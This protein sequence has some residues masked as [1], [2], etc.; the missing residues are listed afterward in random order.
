MELLYVVNQFPKISE[1]FIINELYELDKRGYDITVFAKQRP[2]EEATHEEIQKMGITVYYGEEPALTS[3]PYVCSKDI[4]NKSLLR[5]TLFIDKPSYHIYALHL[6]KQISEV[7]ERVGGVDLIHAHFATPDRLSASYAA[8]YHGIPCTVTAHAH[9]IF[10]PPSVQRLSQV[11][12]RFNHVI[13]PSKYNKRYLRE[14]IEVKTDIS[15]IPA[16]TDVEKF[17]P[18]DGCVSGRLLTVARLVEKK[19]YKY[20]IEAVAELIEQGYN[21]EYHIIGTGERKESVQTRICELGIEDHVKFLGHVSDDELRS[22]LHDAELFILPCVIASNGDRDVAPVAL[23]EAMATETA[24]VSTSVS[25]IPELITSG[26]DG[27]LVEP[28]NSTALADTIAELL[29]NPDRRRELAKNGRNTVRNKFDIS[30]SVDELTEVFD[31]FGK[32]D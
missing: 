27:L 7:V 21:I 19:G 9:E 8:T 3:L 17:E 32:Q 10:S 25:A 31:R 12:S 18:S 11:L 1:S 14:E 15:V 20:A 23:K 2:D 30:D 6:G 4:L 5:Q 13:V 24:C 28:K 16:T 26:E 29:D 22:E